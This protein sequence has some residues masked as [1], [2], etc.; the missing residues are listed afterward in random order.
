MKYLIQGALIA[1]GLLVLIAIFSTWALTFELYQ[2]E[3]KFKVYYEYTIFNKDTI[4]MDT[5]V[6]PIR[7]TILL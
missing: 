3:P 5:I 6:I 1:I 4:P 7:N 2:K